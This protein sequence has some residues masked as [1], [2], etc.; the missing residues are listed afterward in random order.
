MN[1][2]EEIEKRTIRFNETIEKLNMDYLDKIESVKKEEL[3]NLAFGIISQ[4]ED[5]IKSILG[6]E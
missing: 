2:Q 1:R 3:H 5:K 6:G 4:L